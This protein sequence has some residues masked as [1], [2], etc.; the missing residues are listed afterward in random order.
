[1]WSI[2]NVKTIT[3]KVLW[4]H[5][6]QEKK[7]NKLPEPRKLSYT[8]DLINCNRDLAS[9]IHSTL[10]QKEIKSIHSDLIFIIVL[11]FLLQ[12][13]FYS[14]ASKCMQMKFHA[15]FSFFKPSLYQYKNRLAGELGMTFL[16][17]KHWRT[18]A[19]SEK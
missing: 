1:M 3:R 9:S 7:K 18:Y 2:I 6:K 11:S 17:F 14:S 4:L 12:N 19:K 5:P 8:K 10:H 15:F 13:I 16:R